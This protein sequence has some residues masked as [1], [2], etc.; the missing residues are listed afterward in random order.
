MLQLEIPLET[1]YASIDLGN[2]FGIPV[3]LNPAPA[4]PEL[5]LSRITTVNFLVP[6]E[7]ELELLT[8]MPVSSLTDITKA[9]DVLLSVGIRN[10]LV[11]LGPRGA[12]WA[13]SGGNETVTAPTVNAIDTTGAGDAFIGCFA[14][15]WVRTRDVLRSIRSANEYA[16]DSVT[17]HGT[18]T[19]YA[20]QKSC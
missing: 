14:T 15:A 19:S 6:N 8:G 12:L 13:H 18:Q 16:A 2:E 9:T 17:R 3:L 11:T 20:W 7:S 4:S 5:D 1:V 10:V